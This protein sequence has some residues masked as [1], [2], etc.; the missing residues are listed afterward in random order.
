MLNCIF[1]EDRYEITADI[2]GNIIKAFA[3]HAL[4]IGNLVRLILDEKDVLIF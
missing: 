2:D 1:L 4:A 3:P